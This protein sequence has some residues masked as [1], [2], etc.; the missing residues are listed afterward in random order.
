MI[1]GPWTR[2]VYQP[3][4][5]G[6]ILYYSIQT[7]LIVFRDYD[8]MAGYVTYEGYG[9]VDGEAELSNGLRVNLV[10]G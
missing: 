10:T 7:G 2:A 4:Y 6:G 3:D 5:K 9:Y 8:D 1:A